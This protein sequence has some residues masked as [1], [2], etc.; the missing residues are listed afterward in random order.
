MTKHDYFLKYYVEHTAEFLKNYF[1]SNQSRYGNA[2]Q[3]FQKKIE[4]TKNTTSK[5]LNNKHESKTKK[6]DEA[7]KF[8]KRIDSENHDQYSTLK[9]F[10]Q[11]SI[12]TQKYQ[13]AP[14]N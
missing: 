13:I 4:E 8:L 14:D 9:Y 3:D 11:K 5:K 7:L 10:R 2:L 12:L 6:V 1:I